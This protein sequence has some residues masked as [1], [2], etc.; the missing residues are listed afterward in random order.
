[1]DNFENIKWP[2]AIFISGIGTDIGKS[3]A[4]GWLAKRMREEG[5]NTITQKF[6][7]TGC[8]D[9]SEDIEIHRR[10]MG[11]PMQTVDKTHITAPIIYTYPASPELAARIDKKEINL[12]IVDNA[13]RTLLHTYS[14]VLIEGAGGLMVPIKG[15]YL[16]IDYIRERKYPLILVTNGQLGSI[17]DT[18]LSLS[19]ASH[20][21]IRIFAVIW[22]PYFD[23]DKRIAE[24]TRLYLSQWIINHYPDTYFLEMPD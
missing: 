11:I 23:R 1:M 4:T 7:Q 10:I 17:S 5:H 24:E 22:N 21:G 12:H 14:H 8:R 13:T 20:A 15:E 6:I 9:F 3:Y 19:A 16:T 2:E 18:L